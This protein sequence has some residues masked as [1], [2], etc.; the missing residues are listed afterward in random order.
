MTPPS[1]QAVFTLLPVRV[2]VAA[3]SLVR[4]VL[5]GLAQPRGKSSD[6][7]SDVNGGSSGGGSGG[8][9]GDQLFDLLN[10]GLFGATLLLLTRINPGTIYFWMKGMT[11]EFLK[12]SVLFTAL[13][14]SDK[15]WLGPW[16][17]A[18]R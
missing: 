16:A 11:Q 1:T 2:V 10:V 18:R 3:V 15:V 8:L 7:E 12:L 13:E 5:L 4:S 6:G 9:R 14:L 17:G